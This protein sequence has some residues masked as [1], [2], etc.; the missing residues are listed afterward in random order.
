M[1][2]KD[3]K[4]RTKSYFSLV[5]LLVVIAI[6]VSLLVIVVPAFN[7]ITKGMNTEVAART[8]GAKLKAVRGYAIT[9][10]KT[11]A[12]IIPSN[13]E[14]NADADDNTEL[15]KS[16]RGGAYRPCIVDDNDEFIKW[17]PN[18]RWEFLPVGVNVEEI[19]SLVNGVEINYSNISES[20]STQ[21][22]SLTLNGVIF[23]STGDNDPHVGTITISTK[24]G[25]EE[26]EV[27]IKIDNYTGRVSY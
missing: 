22:K 26:N 7:K 19:D 23:K 3:S 15:P 2:I 5:E 16:Y 8:L 27:N 12:L 1:E 4:L 25:K 10:R 18:E 11:I 14:D 24:E 13:D 6:T 21:T 20:D 9:K 17:V